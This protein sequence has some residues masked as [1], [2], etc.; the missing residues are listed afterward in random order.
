M[1]CLRVM[2]CVMLCSVVCGSACGVCDVV[3]GVCRCVWCPPLQAESTVS[4]STSCRSLKGNKF[5][6]AID[7]AP[8]RDPIVENVRHEP[9]ESS[10]FMGV[11]WTSPR[12]A[13]G[14]M[15]PSDRPVKAHTWRISAPVVSA[16]TQKTPNSA[17]LTVA[18]EQ[19]QSLSRLLQWC[20]RLR[21]ER[22]YVLG[23]CGHWSSASNGR[24][25]SHVLDNK[26][27]M[28]IR[29]LVWGLH[30]RCNESGLYALKDNWRSFRKRCCDE[31]G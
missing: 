23:P 13:Y 26:S 22:R 4:Q 6:V 1:L 14:I 10:F 28:C 16:R 21:Q 27:C 31:Y 29:D 15:A 25:W 11:T 5:P 2:L 17:R 7:Q 20:S 24:C 30:V 8:S 18:A 19:S 3:C 9:K 12:H